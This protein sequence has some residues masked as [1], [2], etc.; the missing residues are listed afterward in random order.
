MKISNG[1]LPENTN[2]ISFLNAKKAVLLN[3]TADSYHWGCYGT[4]IEV[5]HSLIEQ[6]F[7]VQPVGVQHTHQT[8]PTVQQVSDFDSNQFFENFQASNQS[9]CDTLNSA[10][11]IVV[12]GE[13]TLHRISKASLNL[14]YIIFFCKKYLKKCVHLINFSYFPNGDTTLPENTSKIYPAVLQHVDKIVPREQASCAI[15]KK[16]GF[17]PTL[18][19]DCL[20]RFLHRY[21]LTNSHISQGHVLLSGGVRFDDKEFE[22]YVELINYLLLKNIPVRFLLG[23]KNH[24]AAEDIQLQKRFKETSETRNIKFIET[25]KMSDWI[26]EFQTASFLFSA[27]FHHT[28]AALSIGTP[29]NFMRSNTPKIS[30]ILDT[31]GETAQETKATVDGLTDVKNAIHLA[32]EKRTTNK[33]QERVEKMLYLADKNFN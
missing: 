7:Y 33:S 14:L 20:P 4:S 30:S 23:A 22:F 13:G 10:D 11:L 31:L 15:L 18:G 26:H 6:G 21:N 16:S 28:V 24:P 3:F 25:K 1:L 32:L 29:F 5:Y 8:S 9:L 17:R 2:G 19:F 12:N 27:R